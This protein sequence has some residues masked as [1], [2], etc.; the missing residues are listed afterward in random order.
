MKIEDFTPPESDEPPMNAALAD[1]MAM[2]AH[3]PQ[4]TRATLAAWIML[5]AETMARECGRRA[6]RETLREM[7]AFIRDAR[8]TREWPE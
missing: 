6:A 4:S 8:P 5:G 1:C 2:A 7:D 3:D